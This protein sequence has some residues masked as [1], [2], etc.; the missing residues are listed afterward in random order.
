MSKKKR[1][2]FALKQRCG[3]FTAQRCGMWFRKKNPRAFN[4]SSVVDLPVDTVMRAWP[5]TTRA[6][7]DFGMKCVGCPIGTFHSVGEA[8]EE[9]KID[10]DLFADALNSAATE[11]PAVSPLTSTEVQP[12]DECGAGRG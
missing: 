10:L 5:G 11:A 6:F 3:N 2:L 12:A 8:C 9:H 1:A 4:K 7:L